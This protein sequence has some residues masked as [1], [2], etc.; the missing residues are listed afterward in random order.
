MSTSFLVLALT[1]LLGSGFAR[2]QVA[3]AE[4][5]PPHFLSIGLGSGILY[6]GAGFN[7]QAE[8]VPGLA[9]MAGLGLSVMEPA[10]ST[11]QSSGI[12]AALGLLY[13]LGEPESRLRPRF[14]INIGENQWRA[15]GIVEGP[16]QIAEAGVSLGAGMAMRFTGRVSL[17]VDLLY[18]F[19]NEATKSAGEHSS[20]WQLAVGLRWTWL[21]ES[22][23]GSSFDD[24][25]Y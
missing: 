5:T 1:V 18:A 12:A 24:L 13:Y 11:Y 15:V 6:G 17:D 8:V 20:A 25:P 16:T 3:P 10:G 21:R 19:Q 14:G 7:G 23:E 22:T 9:L 2:A 4:P